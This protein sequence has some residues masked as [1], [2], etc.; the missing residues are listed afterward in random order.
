MANDRIEIKVAC[1]A[2]GRLFHDK[3]GILRDSDG[4]KVAFVGSAN[5]SIGG[6]RENYERITVFASWQEPSR[7]EECEEDF[8]RLW[9]DRSQIATVTPIVEAHLRVLRE[10]AP[11]YRPGTRPPPPDAQRHWQYIDEHLR[12]DPASTI[13]TIPTRLWPHQRAFFTKHA[14]DNDAPVRKLIAD[15][16][17]LG[18]TLQAASLLKW[19]VN[20]R[21][22]E[23]FLIP[24][25]PTR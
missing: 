8:A 17:G 21:K 18:K 2:K 14:A 25:P 11:A 16:V 6:W 20:Q 3:T 12:H 4:N 23:K 15:E 13:A 19:R 24:N 5:E 22:A 9:K 1:H 7:V 10:R